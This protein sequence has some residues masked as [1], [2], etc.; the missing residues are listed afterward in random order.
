MFAL[1]LALLTHPGMART[2][3]PVSARLALPLCFEPSSL[4]AEAPSNFIARGPNY[5]FMVTAGQAQFIFSQPQTSTG[6]L[7]VRREA[8]P[9]TG[10]AIRR[11]RLSFLGA[12]PL[13][14]LSGSGELEG[15]ANYL[16]GNR[17]DKWRTQVP[18]FSAVR[19]NGLYPGIALTY[20]GNQ[21]QLE[22]DFSIAAKAD[23]S[24]IALRFD[25]VDKLSI[26]T[27]GDL[28]LAVAGAELRQHKPIIYQIVHGVR[29]EV[30]GGYLLLDA[31]TVRFALGP[32]DHDWP[33]VIDPVFSYSTYFGGNAGDTGLAVKVDSSGSVYL[34]GETL[35]TSFPPASSGTPFQSHLSGGT[36]TGDAFVAKLDSTGSKLIYFTYLGGSSDDGAYDLAIDAAGDAFVTGFTVSADF[37]TKNPIFGR[38]SG[39]PDP[40]FQ[41]Y[42][43]EA[44]IAELNPTGSALVFSTY[45]GGSAN[46]L[47]SA[48]ALDPSGYIYV[49]GYTF[50]PDF[51]VANAIQSV[52]GGNDD[53]FVAK[54]TPGGGSIVYSTYLGGVSIDEG[55]GITADPAGYAYVA[56]YTASTNFPVSLG[57]FRTNLNGSGIAVSVYDAFVTRIAPDG[58]SLAYSTYLGGSQNDFG[59]RIALDAQGNAYVTGA[60]QSADFPHTN[61]FGIALGNNGTN[62]I[63]FDAFLTKLDISGTPVYTAQFGGTANDAG[64]DV[65]VDRDGRPFVIGITLSTNFPVTHPFDLFRSTNSGG[66]DI[67]VVAFDTNAAPVLYS[68]YLGGSGDDFGYGIAVDPE[69]S[70][71]LT[72]MTLSP[73][74]PLKPR[75]FQSSLAGSSDSFVAKI[76][77]FDPSLNVQMSG[78][79]FQITWPGTAP[80]YLLQST[81]DLS[82]PQVWSTVPQTPVLAQ[83]QYSLSLPATNTSTLFR[84]E[85]R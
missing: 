75:A 35:S 45:L 61:S 1:G 72:G 43:V 51:P 10:A 80:E 83:G 8:R 16:I 65:A 46:D 13:A 68:A 36:T 57:A 79:I 20:Y 74:F 18:L 19:V 28:V 62:A 14:T 37:P 63:N 64:W 44:F 24:A 56:G 31:R 70:A 41:V 29:H 77:L 9:V 6:S 82:P 3:D 49:T 7:S 78:G 71:Y 67:F 60:T 15:K 17:P 21:R 85:H 55:E 38:I 32:Y 69:S 47:G 12:D 58:K 27:Q 25:G 39:S 48:I 53:A 42:P 2:M 66:K 30:Q 33:L 4:E 54:L 76:R 26:S 22:Y 52:L 73:A 40:K 23:A 81:T 5:Q 34:A 11:V 59:Y 84:L 50:S